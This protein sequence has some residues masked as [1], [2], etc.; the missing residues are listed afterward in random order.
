MKFREGLVDRRGEAALAFHLRIIRTRAAAF[1]YGFDGGR[2]RDVR[3]R[4]NDVLLLM[5]SRLRTDC[6]KP[7]IGCCHFQSLA[8][9]TSWMRP[10]FVSALAILPEMIF[11]QLGLDITIEV[12]VK[13]AQKAARYTS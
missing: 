8:A 10:Q 11:D 2:K 13:P 1:L 12:Q 6:P 5:Q 4:R 9:A 7:A 3:R